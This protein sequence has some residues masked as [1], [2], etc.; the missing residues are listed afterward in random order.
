MSVKVKY[1]KDILTITLDRSVGT[2]ALLQDKLQ[3]LTGVPVASQ[4]IVPA[5]TKDGSSSTAA[6]AGKNLMLFGSA[7]QATAPAQPVL[8][9]EDAGMPRCLDNPGNMCYIN[10]IAQIIH[11]APALRQFLQSRQGEGG[12]GEPLIAEFNELLAKLDQVERRRGGNNSNR[13]DDDDRASSSSSSSVSPMPFV[14]KLIA[15]FPNPFGTR[16][17]SPR[18]GGLM[19]HNPRAALEAIFTAAT[20]AG[21]QAGSSSSNNNNGS[22]TIITGTATSAATGPQPFLVLPCAINSDVRFLEQGVAEAMK[23]KTITALPAKYLIVEQMRFAP[24]LV[25]TRIG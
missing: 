13:D 6:L 9:A 25:E 21:P 23:G 1:G 4:K 19:Q 24:R 10:G 15:K 14:E 18:N 12:S 16:F 5:L 17:G 7:V 11:A 22:E 3:Q 8:F 20:A 2:A